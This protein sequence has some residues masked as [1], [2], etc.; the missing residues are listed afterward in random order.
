[1]IGTVRVVK[2][3]A[4]FGFIEDDENRAQHFFHISG[5]HVPFAD[6]LEGSRV[7]FN[8]SRGPRGLRA[9]QVRLLP[10]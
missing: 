2:R 1:M 6:L 10:R 4:G 3:D 9:T 7:E 8:A 5:L